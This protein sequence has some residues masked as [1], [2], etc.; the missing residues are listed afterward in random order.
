MP[1]VNGLKTHCEVEGE[2][3]QVD[4]VHGLG[5]S[6]KVWHAQREAL[7][8]HFRVILYDRSGAGRYQPKFSTY[9]FGCHFV[10]VTWQPEITRLRVSRVV[11]VIDASRILN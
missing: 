11:T 1:T 3:P 7:R 4:F 10:E 2:G 8:T 9:S 6:S 5:A